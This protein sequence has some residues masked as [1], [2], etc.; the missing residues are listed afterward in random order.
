[1]ILYTQHELANAIHTPT[2]VIWGMIFEGAMIMALV[3]MVFMWAA[4]I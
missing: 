2:P 3:G 4:I 1:M